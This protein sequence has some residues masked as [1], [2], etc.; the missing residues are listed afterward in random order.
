MDSEK[1]LHDV[2]PVDPVDHLLSLKETLSQCHEELA[3]TLPGDRSATFENLGAALHS[4]AEHWPNLLLGASGG[5][6]SEDEVEA[7]ECFRQALVML[8]VDRKEHF[9][10]L[11]RLAAAIGTR[12]LRIEHTAELAEAVQYNREVLQLQPA[13][14]PDRSTTVLL[15][16]DLMNDSWAFHDDVSYLDE[17]IEYWEEALETAKDDQVQVHVLRLLVIGYLERYENT[18]RISDLLTGNKY[19]RQHLQLGYHD[20][21]VYQD[22]NCESITVLDHVEETIRLRR[23]K[24]ELQAIDD[25]DRPR[26]VMILSRIFRFRFGSLKDMADLETAI[27]YN[28]DATEHT[29]NEF[30]PLTLDDLSDALMTRVMF[31]EKKEDVEEVIKLR[32]KRLEICQ[33]SANF[34]RHNLLG[35]LGDAISERYLQ[36][37]NPGDLE[38]TIRLYREA[39]ELVPEGGTLLQHYTHLCNLASMLHRRYKRTNQL[40]D[41]DEALEINSRALELLPVGTIHY[42]KSLEDL[43]NSL[44]MENGPMAGDGEDFIL[45]ARLWLS[46]GL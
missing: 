21:S 46:L 27:Q 17:G 12:A 32:R 33:R 44:T 45:E 25:P 9:Y 10:A 38:E 14:D 41:R 34:Q 35:R 26:D 11:K 1:E 20:H 2:T 23:R 7:I 39:V 19:C 4:Y 37:N 29:S 30:Y 28:R 40:K 22:P 36:Q 42:A 13:G 24:L 43:A 15:L 6:P 31:T 16:A 8:P 3:L 5:E 18:G